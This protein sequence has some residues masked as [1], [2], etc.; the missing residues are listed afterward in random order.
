MNVVELMSSHAERFIY[1]GGHA[2]AG[3]F[4]TTAEHI[5]ELETVLHETCKNMPAPEKNTN[6]VPHDMTITLR[7]VTQDHWKAIR[8]LSPFGEGNPKP[9]FKFE[10]VIV[11]NVRCFGKQKEHLEITVTDSSGDRVQAKSFYTTPASYDAELREGAKITLYGTMD[12]SLFMG[13][14][15]LCIRIL[16]IK[17]TT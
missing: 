15:N 10:N 9:V 17:P 13:R 7:D 4:S 12:Y 11:T 6:H 14:G 8:E 1:F 5:H 16:D 3:G 2:G